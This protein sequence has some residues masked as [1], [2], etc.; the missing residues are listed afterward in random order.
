MVHLFV[1]FLLITSLT[2]IT[3]DSKS[4]NTTT[5]IDLFA[6]SDN[7]SL[8]N[9]RRISVFA[10]YQPPVSS[11][12]LPFRA[13]E[14]MTYCGHFA[15]LLQ[16]LSERLDLRPSIDTDTDMSTLLQIY[17]NYTT[18]KNVESMFLSLYEKGTYIEHFNRR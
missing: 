10:K 8:A 1:V 4:T 3:A 17:R 11:I 7:S 14:S 16:M 12:F 6:Y 13:N 5:A 2:R 18:F 15:F 9:A